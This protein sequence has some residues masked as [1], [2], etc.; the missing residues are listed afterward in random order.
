MRFQAWVIVVVAL[1]VGCHPKTG[2]D[3]RTGNVLVEEDF[4]EPY[5][6][7]Y[8]SDEAAGTNL[9]VED[10]AYHMTVNGGGYIWG[11]GT[12][13]YDNVVFEAQSTQ[14]SSFANNAY[15]LMCRADPS[16]NGDGYYFLIS[17]DGY[18][19]I[20][21]TRTGTNR[22]LVDFTRTDAISQG[23][24]INTLR[25]VCIDDYFALYVNDQ[26]VGDATDDTLSHGYVGFAVA[27]AKEGEAEVYFDD[28][29][30]WTGTLAR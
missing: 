28:A 21:V 22:A 20:R 24:S 16:N 12:D 5:T 17:G 10:G 1:L 27:A 30:V 25:A 29:T 9:R 15:G 23:Q 3:Y 14:L 7:E 2:R 11:L 19:S 26:F 6:W 13:D 4:S 8:Y 18:W